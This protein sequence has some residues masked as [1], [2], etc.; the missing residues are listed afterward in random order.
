MQNE[1]RGVGLPE[2]VPDNGRLYLTT[3]MART[4][5]KLRQVLQQAE[6]PVGEP[7][8][9]ILAVHLTA[10]ELQQL[11]LGWAEE[12]NK[13]ELSLTKCHV[14][15]DGVEPAVSELMHSHSLATLIAWIDGQWLGD[16]L[17][18][19]RLVTHFQPI[20]HSSQPTQVF[21]H[22]CLLRGVEENG[23][24]VP[25]N[26]L[27][28]A[29]RAAGLLDSLDEAARLTAIASA[30]QPWLRTN[31]F[32]NFNPR[33]ISDPVRFLESTVQAAAVRG[34]PPER[35]VF[36]VVESDKVDDLD[37]LLDI[38]DYLRSASFRVALDDLGAGYSSLNLLAQ[39]KPDFVKL[40]MTL[41][42][43]V[44][45][46][47]YKSRIASKLLELARELEVATVAEGVETVGEWKWATEHGA[48]YA[49]GYLFARP[50]HGPSLVRC[51]GEESNAALAKDALLQEAN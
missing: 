30:S 29:A 50:S 37:K 31:V 16:L 7:Y 32:I 3:P 24:L 23:E 15:S 28:S 25:P 19:Q 11:S 39:L 12:L 36:E 51:P 10:R 45:R 17:R 14:A 18:A 13:V 26:R 47:L 48:D 4:A 34:I 21:A 42:R 6:R 38:I 49:Q 40:D 41:I 2:L 1:G 44:D 8:P 9:G 22:E 20:V 46:D 35:I 5:L 43:D 33:S 27:Y